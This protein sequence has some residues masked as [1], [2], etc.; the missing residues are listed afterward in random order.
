MNVND[1]C[2][3]IDKS[4]KHYCIKDSNGDVISKADYYDFNKKNFDWI[5]IC[6]VETK[7]EFRGKGLATKIMDSLYTDLLHKYPSKGLYLLVKTDNLSAISL[8]K[9]INFKIAKECKIKDDE[10][11]VMYKGGANKQQLIDMNFR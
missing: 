11:Y 10:Y 9:K 1:F 4:A 2:T 7:P 3:K 6:N 8:Y 5:L